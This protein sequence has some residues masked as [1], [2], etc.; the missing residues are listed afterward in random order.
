MAIYFPQTSGG[1][2]G[3]LVNAIHLWD[4][5][6]G[7]S[8]KRRE[9][10]TSA[11]RDSL[12]K[13]KAK[14]ADDEAY[15]WVQ[16]Q[17]AVSPAKPGTM[18][19][20]LS[21]E[22]R[23]NL[24]LNFKASSPKAD[25][26][27]LPAAWNK[28][29]EN[30]LRVNSLKAT[31]E[32]A[33]AEL[34]KQKQDAAAKAAAELEAKRM[35]AAENLFRSGFSASRVPDEPLSLYDL[36]SE[37]KKPEQWRP[38][39]FD[40]DMA[41]HYSRLPEVMQHDLD[42]SMGDLGLSPTQSANVWNK[43]VANLTGLPGVPQGMERGEV[44]TDSNGNQTS[45]KLGTT[46][47][48]EAK[49][50]EAEA[51]KKEKDEEKYQAQRGQ[52]AKFNESVNTNFE[53]RKLL[54]SGAAYNQMRAQVD[55]ANKLAN[56][57]DP[58]AKKILGGYDLAIIKLFNIAIEPNSVVRDAEFDNAKKS[59]G[60]VA[61]AIN[62]VEGWTSGQML[63]P[64]Q[65]ELLLKAAQKL[66]EG[67]LQSHNKWL[68]ERKRGEIDPLGLPKELADT[69]QP[70]TMD[71]LTTYEHPLAKL[72]F[73]GGEYNSPTLGHSDDPVV[74]PSVL[75]P[76]QTQSA[77]GLL[78][79]YAVESKSS[80]WIVNPQNGKLLEFTPVSG[81]T[82][83]PPGSTNS[84][85]LPAV[86]AAGS[87][88]VSLPVVG[89]V[90]DVGVT[91]SVVAPA[92]VPSVTSNSTNYVSAS[93]NRGVP[94][95]VPNGWEKEYGE[96]EP[97]QRAGLNQAYANSALLGFGPP[98]KNTNGVPDVLEQFRNPALE[99]FNRY[100][101]ELARFDPALAVEFYGPRTPEE[102]DAISATARAIQKDYEEQSRTN[103]VN[104]SWLNPIF[105]FL[106][107]LSRGELSR[108]ELSRPNTN[109]VV[110]PDTEVP[111]W[112]EILP[113]MGGYNYSNPFNLPLP[114]R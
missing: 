73:R 89:D 40:R 4:Q 60:L 20:E 90:S 97:E 19:P 11:L 44:T 84:V 33:Q 21:D 5:F 37:V 79:K 92:S 14:Q 32:A 36:P 18:F 50:A 48:L 3:N 54:E 12:D 112:K 59:G 68:M 23:T 78:K 55:A 27:R 83:G 70:W 38:P 86:N 22:D 57:T 53:T 52:V 105:D 9:L 113:R 35:Q 51:K 24:D 67:R 41:V 29:Q 34:N 110:N 58:D 65:R 71:N 7:P 46:A 69:V 64:A 81:S 85:A 63:Q 77:L 1:G 111:L 99:A 80:V 102:L 100:S 39:Q 82:N 106:G 91:N 108:G 101:N 31:Q 114:K 76:E 103:S 104:S 26:T 98:D 75:S 15:N 107:E 6:F 10:E 2:S 17:Q 74:L 45:A 42:I 25:I 62:T 47:E 13:E 56:S 72:G 87:N 28:F 93:A 96:L 30:L 94:N 16:S 43:V 109:Q 66:I 8:S 95:W 49:K 88:S 61:T